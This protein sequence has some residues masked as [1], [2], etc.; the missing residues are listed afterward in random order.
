MSEQTYLTNGMGY[1]LYR[2]ITF[3]GHQRTM[4]FRDNDAWPDMPKSIKMKRPIIKMSANVPWWLI[5][6]WC[7]TMA[8]VSTTQIVLCYKMVKI[9]EQVEMLQGYEIHD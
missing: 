3:A 4:M 7:V 5:L 1:Y 2:T 8:F 6:L 9:Q